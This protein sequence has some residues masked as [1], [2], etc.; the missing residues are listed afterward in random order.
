VTVKLA[1][2]LV[3]AVA[4]YLITPVGT[5]LLAQETVDVH[6]QVV[7]G[8]EG[9]ELPDDLNVLMLITSGDGMLTGTGQTE[10]DALGRFVFEDVQVEPGGSYT[11]SVDHLGIFYGTSFGAEG[12]L[13]D[14][15]LTVY[16]TTGDAS[17]ITVERQVMVIAAVDKGD[18]LVSAIEFVQI[19]NP[20][21][22]TLVPDLATSV[23]QI[24]FLRFALPP[25][26]A[27]LTVNSD[28]PPGDIVSIGT[29]FAF[30]SPV[31]PGPH[32]IDFSYSVPFESES[33]SYRQSLVQGA[34]IFQVWVPE[35]ISGVEIRG[36]DS[37]D[38][39]NVQG[40]SYRAYEGRDFPPGQGLQLEITGLPLPGVWTRFTGTVKG[41]HFWQVA[42][43]SALGATLAAMLLWGM[44][45]G[46][47]P[48]PAVGT[49]ATGP[50]TLTPAERAAVVRS[51]A[52]LDQRFQGGDI[53]EVEYRAQRIEL[54]ASVLE[55]GSGEAE[56]PLVERPE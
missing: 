10:P 22:R 16:E 43:P 24:S 28:L 47:G 11:V 48:T 23:D 38:P 50:H 19:V 49:A 29:G 52:A 45:R 5:S 25:N 35:V 27:E 46:Y 6:G 39:V 1:L 15:L 20:T 3:L 33:L 51:V 32:S 53:P 41:G 2:L 56:A 26:P 55:P 40:T 18:Q 31:V 9:A 17:I 37:I 4:L 54:M 7:N 21:D 12:I 14:V 34:G 36:L 30:T 13:D 8:T 44:I 42:I